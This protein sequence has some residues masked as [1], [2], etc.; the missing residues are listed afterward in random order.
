MGSVDVCAEVLDLELQDPFGVSSGTSTTR[1]N[2]RIR[3]RGADGVEGLGEAA[4]LGSRGQTAQ[5][6]MDALARLAGLLA[7]HAWW[8]LSGF[9]R[10]AALAEPAQTAARAGLSMARH[11]LAARRLGVPLHVLLGHAAGPLPP[12]SFTVGIDT[13]EE[14]LRKASAVADWPVVKVKLG[15]EGDLNVLRAIRGVY[16]GRLLVDVNG[17]WTV[18]RALAAGPVLCELGV[19][20]L[21]QPVPGPDVDGLAA[22]AAGV[23]LPVYADESVSDLLDV[24]GLAGKVGGVNIKL[25]KAGGLREALGMIQSA[26]ACG[27]GVMLGCMI[28]SGVGIA[29]A[30]AIA[31]L[32]DYADL[33]GAALLRQDPHPLV[34]LEQGRLF[35]NPG[36]GLGDLA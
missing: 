3:L 32:V 14:M 35:A 29:A 27:L 5:T 11:D 30:V 9:E 13:A 20:V 10:A 12:S 18:D 2:V 33:D 36:D 23:K 24:I 8:D 34:R 16:G 4:V 1:R 25:A 7:E 28:E 6:A 22:V 21:E 15:F 26:R 19:E 17:G 31:P